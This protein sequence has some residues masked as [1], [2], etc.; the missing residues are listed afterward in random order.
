MVMLGRQRPQ[1]KTMMR[2]SGRE[3]L[4][5]SL[6]RCPLRLRNGK[7]QRSGGPSTQPRLFPWKH[8][9]RCIP[10]LRQ[11]PQAPLAR[12]AETIAQS[13]GHRLKCRLLDRVPREGPARNLF[14]SL[15]P[16]SIPTQPLLIR[17]A[18]RD[19]SILQ[20]SSTQVSQEHDPGFVGDHEFRAGLKR[21]RLWRDPASPKN[22]KLILANRHRLAIVRSI[23]IECAL[24][25]AH[26]DLFSRSEVL[27]C[28]TASSGSPAHNLIQPLTSQLW[29]RLGLS[30]TERSITVFAASMS[31]VLK[32]P[33]VSAET[34][35][36]S[37]SSGAAS[38]A[39]CARS[40][41]WRRVL[42]LSSAQ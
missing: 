15:P 17:A 10:A 12:R 11:Q 4:S 2:A 32:Y 14:A 13:S 19:A 5:T 9:G 35:S 28:F 38:R 8:R 21:N 37:G 16:F 31:S 30:A 23:Q 29:A 26:A 3:Q 18:F 25:E 20:P 41:A 39:R 22:R 24:A 34:A 7:S 40:S 1:T 33:K 36:A 42:S 27:K 6:A